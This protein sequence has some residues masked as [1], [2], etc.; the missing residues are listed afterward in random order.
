M[1]KEVNID[2][3]GG[4]KAE[5]FSA[6]ASIKK[7]ELF[8]VLDPKK[9]KCHYVNIYPS[10]QPM[11]W[12]ATQNWEL[13]F[14]SRSV[15]RAHLNFVYDFISAWGLDELPYQK[16]ISSLK[17]VL[18]PNGQVF[19]REP[20]IPL[21]ILREFFE[22]EG[23]VISESVRIEKQNQTPTYAS[24]IKWAKKDPVGEQQSIYFP[25]EFVATLAPQ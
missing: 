17:R 19:V 24:F 13:P 6:L 7:D 5:Y 23:F 2:I 20:K 3:G 25:M 4:S 11:R 12:G 9:F 1:T 15:D 8:I 22:R 10:L 14:R 16:L 21:E 18:K